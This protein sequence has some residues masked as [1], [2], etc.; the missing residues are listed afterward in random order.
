ML[1]LPVSFLSGHRSWGLTYL[2]QRGDTDGHSRDRLRTD[3]TEWQQYR[4]GQS[5]PLLSEDRR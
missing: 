5:L 2:T 1:L 3:I 4:D